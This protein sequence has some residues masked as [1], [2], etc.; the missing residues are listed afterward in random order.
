MQ[1]ARLA[2]VSADGSQLPAAVETAFEQ[3]HCP[4]VGEPQLLEIV[5]Y[6]PFASRKFSCDDAI[7][8]SAICASRALADDKYP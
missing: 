5:A 1:F 3:L 8:R 2:V 6:P 7:M 4:V